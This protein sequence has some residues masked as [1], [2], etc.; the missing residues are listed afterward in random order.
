MLLGQVG[1]EGELAGKGKEQGLGL[2]ATVSP[3]GPGVGRGWVSILSTSRLTTGG[4]AVNSKAFPFSELK[5]AGS[6]SP[7]TLLRS[8]QAASAAYSRC[9]RQKHR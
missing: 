2:D 4:G 3:A 7:R 9:R 5:D 1:K 8:E 6:G